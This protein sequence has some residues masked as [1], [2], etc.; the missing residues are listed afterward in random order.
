MHPK[1][2][3]HLESQGAIV[4]ESLAC[5]GLDCIIWQIDG[6]WG[7][8]CDAHDEYPPEPFE[9]SEDAMKAALLSHEWCDECRQ[10]LFFDLE[11]GDDD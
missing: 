8:T 4:V 1:V 3:E 6:G 11:D 9:T 7:V 2:I 5:P 10:E